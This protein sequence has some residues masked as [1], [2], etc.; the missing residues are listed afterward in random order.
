LVW[1]QGDAAGAG[2][3]IIKDVQERYTELQCVEYATYLALPFSLNAVYYDPSTVTI[4]LVG[5]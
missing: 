4:I 2:G 3:K 1:G 5:T